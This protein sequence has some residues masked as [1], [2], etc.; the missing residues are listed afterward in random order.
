MV[1]ESAFSTAGRSSSAMAASN[2]MMIGAAM[3]TV[4]PS[5]SWNWPLTWVSGSI[6][7]NEPAT[8]TA[9]PSWPTTVPPHL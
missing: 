6:V 1:T 5:D 2:C 4:W 8:G 7:V 3:P 9:L